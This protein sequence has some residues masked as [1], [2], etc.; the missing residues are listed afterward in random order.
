MTPEE[1]ER[2]DD[3]N[4]RVRR[5]ARDYAP[6]YRPLVLSLGYH[7]NL[8]EGLGRTFI[9][10]ETVVRESARYTASGKPLQD[11]YVK[12]LLAEMIKAGALKSEA[13]YRGD[14][15]RRTSSYR[16]LVTSV[17]L[18]RKGFTRAH[19]FNAPFDEFPQVD[20]KKDTAQDT[21]QDTRTVFELAS[22]LASELSPN[23]DK[24]EEDQKQDQKQ[25][26]PAAQTDPRDLPPDDPDSLW[27]VFYLWRAK[28]GSLALFS[29]AD[30]GF[31]QKMIPRRAIELRL[32]PEGSDWYYETWASWGGAG[33][34]EDR[35]KLIARRFGTNEELAE[36]GIDRERA[37]SSN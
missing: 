8:D 12:R 3:W 2:L 33:S 19:D 31:D 18:D 14:T 1:Q 34:V 15:G 17:A 35:A 20:E 29:P 24:T 22:E 32:S 4:R 16:T 26:G 36:L 37:P 10:A 7:V 21:A 11:R 28:S 13:R 25:S 30:M 9:K 23:P 5:L 27:N 6:K